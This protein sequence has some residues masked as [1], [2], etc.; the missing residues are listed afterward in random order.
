L[1][2]RG[3]AWLFLRWLGAQKGDDVYSRLVQ[4]GLRSGQNV[5]SATGESFAALFGD[6]TIA[7][8]ADSIPG[9]PR[10]A[11]SAR[12]RTGPRALRALLA[13]GLGLTLYPLA[14]RQAPTP[15][16][17]AAS[18]MV[19]GTATYYTTTVPPGGVT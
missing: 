12:F 3:V 18:S 15:G 9:L 11:V 2:E 19:Q 8:F 17:V 7:L 16:T 4:T 1:E 13:R 14:I 10:S 5:E 6:F